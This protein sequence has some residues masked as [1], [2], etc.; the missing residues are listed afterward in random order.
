MT[1]LRRRR[2]NRIGTLDQLPVDVERQSHILTWSMDKGNIAVWKDKPKGLD[3]MRFTMDVFD[4]ELAIPKL[5]VRLGFGRFTQLGLRCLAAQ[6]P[7]VLHAAK[8]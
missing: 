7:I 3:I 2:G 8:S 1:P 6:I 5:A 4:H